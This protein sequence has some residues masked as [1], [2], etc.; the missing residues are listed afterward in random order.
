MKISNKII[1]TILM[2]SFFFQSSFAQSEENLQAISLDSCSQKAAALQSQLDQLSDKRDLG[3]TISSSGIV[4]GTGGIGYAISTTTGAGVATIAPHLAISTV[5]VGTGLIIAGA[6]TATIAPKS[7]TDR[8]QIAKAL[9]DRD[10]NIGIDLIDGNISS[11]TEEYLS[12]CMSDSRIEVI[13]RNNIDAI[14]ASLNKGTLCEQDYLSLIPEVQN[15]N[16][17]TSK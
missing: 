16:E 11:V 10:F 1:L 17:T 12:F 15:S 8:V 3:T 5:T 6:I 14:K 9:Y 4:V 2:S 13:C 7:E